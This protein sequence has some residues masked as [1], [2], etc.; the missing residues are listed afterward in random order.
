MKNKIFDSSG[1]LCEEAYL[2]TTVAL[3]IVDENGKTIWVY[4][5]PNSKNPVAAAVNNLYF[6]NHAVA[7]HKARLG[8]PE[9][10]PATELASF[11]D[12]F[13]GYASMSGDLSDKALAAEM[14]IKY[15]E[16]YKTLTGFEFNEK[17]PRSFSGSPIPFHPKCFDI[18][19]PQ[20]KNTCTNGVLHKAADYDF[21]RLS[22]QNEFA[23]KWGSLQFPDPEVAH[24]NI[25]G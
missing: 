15:K 12:L 13:M 21:T 11:I 14:Y 4:W 2:S 9:L 5:N 6:Y 10:S 18:E 22:G 1:R 25:S 17:S 3:K 19:L 7:K 24:P 8:F 23:L 20:Q 16:L